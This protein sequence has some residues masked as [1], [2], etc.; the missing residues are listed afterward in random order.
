[1]DRRL[2]VNPGRLWAILAL[3]GRFWRRK[4]TVC[5]VR[6]RSPLGHVELVGRDVVMKGMMSN[7]EAAV[8]MNVVVDRSGGLAQP[9]S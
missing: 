5:L 9:G 1:M 2:F 6:M 8:S 3:G 4:S 7:F